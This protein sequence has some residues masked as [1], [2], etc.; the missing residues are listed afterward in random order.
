MKNYFFNLS[1][2]GII[3]EF[4]IAAIILK[5]VF[6]DLVKFNNSAI[7]ICIYL[8]LILGAMAT[9]I[10]ARVLDRSDWKNNHL[11]AMIPAPVIIFLVGIIVGSLVSY[12]GHSI[13]VERGGLFSHSNFN[14]YFNKPVYWFSLIGVPCCLILGG[15]YRVFVMAILKKKGA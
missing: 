9:I 3:T 8:S 6:W 15:L 10:T 4:L 2:V 14:N 1:I 13:L 7:S 12:V 11:K 5:G